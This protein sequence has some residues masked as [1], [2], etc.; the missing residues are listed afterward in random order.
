MGD[1]LQRPLSGGSSFFGGDPRTPKSR[2]ASCSVPTEVAVMPAE[3]TPDIA[4]MQFTLA[5]VVAN[6]FAGFLR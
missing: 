3:L 5:R 6:S 4:N 2:I 1:L